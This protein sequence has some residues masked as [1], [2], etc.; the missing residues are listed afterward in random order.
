MVEFLLTSYSYCS[1]YSL[2]NLNTATMN[3]LHTTIAIVIVIVIVIYIALGSIVC[4]KVLFN[5]EVIIL[6]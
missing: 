2:K 5:L 1:P 6:T 4:S 3:L